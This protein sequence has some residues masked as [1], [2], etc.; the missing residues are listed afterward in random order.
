[1]NN[2]QDVMVELQNKQHIKI[3]PVNFLSSIFP[4][5][6]LLQRI[7]SVLLGSK[8]WIPTGVM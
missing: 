5:I 1:M 2:P 7:P 8:I 6:S 4:E 3:C